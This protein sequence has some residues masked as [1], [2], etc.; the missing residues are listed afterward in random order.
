MEE[1]HPIP[2][3]KKTL[4]SRKTFMKKK[5]KKAVTKTLFKINLLV[6]ENKLLKNKTIK[7]KIEARLI[8]LKFEL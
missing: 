3:R 6:W 4:S 2:Y 1:I 7:T 8:A 5:H